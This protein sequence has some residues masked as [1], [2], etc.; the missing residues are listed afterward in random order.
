MGFKWREINRDKIVGQWAAL[1]VTL[2]RKGEIVISRVTWERF[3][4]PAAVHVL[5]DDT[6]Q[7]IG[8]KPTAPAM[9]NADPVRKITRH[10][11]RRIPAFRLLAETNIRIEDTIQFHDAE[12]DDDGT[13][14]LNLRTARISNR[15]LNH[16]ANRAK[17]GKIEGGQ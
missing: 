3:G 8:L 16:R 10:G 7:R 11:A 9:R 1:Y 5:F 4:G 2:N 17:R 14:V 13:L 12:I 15:A 6:N